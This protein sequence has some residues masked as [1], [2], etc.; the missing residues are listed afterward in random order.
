[1]TATPITFV[2]GLTF[3]FN[4]KNHARVIKSNKGFDAFFKYCKDNKLD[5]RIEIEHARTIAYN[6]FNQMKGE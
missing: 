4:K 6:Q 2:F 1:M 5:W 3:T